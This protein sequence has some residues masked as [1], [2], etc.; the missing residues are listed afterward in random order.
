MDGKQLIN[1]M[2]CL[3][4]NEAIGESGIYEMW[5]I[6]NYIDLQILSYMGV[7]LF[8]FN[9]QGVVLLVFKLCIFIYL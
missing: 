1:D 9:K 2:C 6:G 8:N 5:Y 3:M 7:L 4:D